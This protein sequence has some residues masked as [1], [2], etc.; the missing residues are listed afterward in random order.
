LVQGRNSTSAGGMVFVLSLRGAGLAVAGFVRTGLG[1]FVVIGKLPATLADTARLGDDAGLLVEAANLLDGGFVMI[2]LPG[3]DLELVIRLRLALDKPAV[4][5]AADA[6]EEFVDGFRT[7]AA[8]G[9]PA[10]RAVVDDPMM[11]L[12]GAPP[13]RLI[14]GDPIMPPDG[15]PPGRAVVRDPLMALEGAPPGRAVMRDPVIAPGGVPPE[16]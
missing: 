2:S 11:A 14:V 10:G 7:T 12:E 8:A 3:A 13:G 5:R 9:A 1:D 6:A 4:P 16:R 15:A